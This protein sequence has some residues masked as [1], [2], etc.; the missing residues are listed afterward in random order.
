[1][2]EKVYGRKMIKGYKDEIAK[3]ILLSWVICT[4]VGVLI[5]ASIVG[6]VTHASDKDVEPVVEQE[7]TESPAHGI[8]EEPIINSEILMNWNNGALLDFVPLDVPLDE[9]LQKFI[10][11]LSHDYNIDFSFVMAL[12]NQES[13][14]ITDITSSTNDFGLMQINKVNHEWLMETLGVTDF[15]DPYQNVRCGIFILRNLFEKYEDPARVLMAYNMGETGAKRL[16]DKG[17]F[18]SNYSNK[19]ITKAAEYQQQISERKGE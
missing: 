5:G 9:D 3:R 15:N 11:C 17:I 18:E 12:I 13:S 1:M 14:F 6:V 7:Q 2:N 8:I 10:Y 4:L 16:W 19:V